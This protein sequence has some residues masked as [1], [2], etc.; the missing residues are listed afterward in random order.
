MT[1]LLGILFK[2]K[3]KLFSEMFSTRNIKYK[4]QRAVQLKYL[5]CAQTKQRSLRERGQMSR[6]RPF[7][8]PG[9]KCSPLGDNFSGIFLFYSMCHLPFEL[10]NTTEKVKLTKNPK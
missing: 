9:I 8:E 10:I 2:V 5:I 1:Y 7:S 4:K 6:L 3:I